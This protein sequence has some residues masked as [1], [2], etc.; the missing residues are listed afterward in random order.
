MH[1]MFGGNPGHS[2]TSQM[3][4]D[5][6]WTLTVRHPA[7]TQRSL[8]H[9]VC[10]CVCMCVCV[11]VV[12][13]ARAAVQA[14]SFPS[15]PVHAT[16]EQVKWRSERK[17]CVG[18]AS[19]STRYEELVRSEPSRALHYLQTAVAEIVNHSNAEQSQQFR[20]LASC[21]FTAGDST[22]SCV[23]LNCE[24]VPLPL[25]DDFS[26][27]REAREKVG[28]LCPTHSAPPILASFHSCLTS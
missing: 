9:S 11:C 13:A 4:L 14:S 5:D 26:S 2:K 10:V 3:R 7:L 8:V 25:A 17:E 20:R 28:Y 19:S 27:R 24:L 1:F 6:L 21:L 23:W 18:T 15:L 12:S 22:H 16:Q